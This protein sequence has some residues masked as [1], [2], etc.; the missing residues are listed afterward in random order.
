[1]KNTTI[2]TLFFLILAALLSVSANA[3]SLKD[4]L[5]VKNF[6]AKGDSK[7]LDTAAINKAIAAAHAKGGGTVYFPKGKYLANGIIF[8]SNVTLH[9][10]KNGHIVAAKD[11]YNHPEKNP[12]DLHQ[13]FGHSHYHNSLIL[14]EDV[15]NVAIEGQGEIRCEDLKQ[16]N[17]VAPGFGD[18][19]I[20]VRRAKNVRFEDFTMKGGGHFAVIIKNS[21]DI[22][23]RQVTIMAMRDG[24]NLIDSQNIDID[25]IFVESNDDSIAM[26]SDYAE[27]RKLFSDNIRVR[28]SMLKNG[29]CHAIRFG[30][31]T[32]GDFRNIVFE[33]IQILASNK[34]GIVITP[35]DG[36]HIEN[37]VFRDISMSMVTYPIKLDVTRRST[38]PPGAPLRVRDKTPVYIPRTPKPHAVGKIDGIS[39]ENIRIY[40]V[41]P[42]GWPILVKGT[43]AEKERIKNISFKNIQV[44]LIGESYNEWLNKESQEEA[45]G[46]Q[47]EYAQNVNINGMSFTFENKNDQRPVVLVDDAVNFVMN[48]VMVEGSE[49]KKS[50]TRL[51]KLK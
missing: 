7:T 22:V 20:A 41:Q 44:E 11:G 42:G 36:A 27:G 48:G 38:K 18:K 37:V 8:K 29:C 32:V 31:E 10:S 46:I 26:K 3:A 35:V 15:E 51:T 25:Q 16:G 17:I 47:I 1:M 23:M 39:F 33:N 4:A 45:K 9:L 34:G 2:N 19:A 28:N 6:G 12:Y 50:D 24:I 21:R 5:N 14:M 49:L 30:S 40:D 13:D 43:K